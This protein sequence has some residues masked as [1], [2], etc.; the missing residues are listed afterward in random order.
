M[1]KKRNTEIILIEKSW[2]I[3]TG[4]S[5]LLLDEFKNVTIYEDAHDFESLV[6]MIEMTGSCCV[7]INSEIME[8]MKRYLHRIPE[9][10]VI[11]P[12]VKSGSYA[13]IPDS[14]KHRIDINEDK[15][16]IIQTILR[17]IEPINSLNKNEIPI[18]LLT[19]REQLILQLIAKGYSSKQIADY[20]GISLNTVITHRKNISAK[21]DIKTVSG[22]T[23]YAIINNLLRADET[24]IQ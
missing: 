7:I 13:S 19:K 10:S 9:H 24:N 22:L 16:M 21:L 8:G 5:I 15:K 2:I 4:L 18:E 23:V 3:R 12:L 14:F 6:S 11:I 1:R 17:A 20:L